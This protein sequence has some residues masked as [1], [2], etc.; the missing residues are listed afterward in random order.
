MDHWI[1]GEPRTCYELC[2]Q[3]FLPFILV[4]ILPGTQ[5]SE[6]SLS[7]FGGL[8]HYYYPTC[9]V[10][11]GPTRALIPYYIIDFQVQSPSGPVRMRKANPMIREWLIGLSSKDFNLDALSVA[12]PKPDFIL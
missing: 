4:C 5:A 3:N 1:H 12:A 11:D 2:Q 10:V 9:A 6:A 8:S 7:G